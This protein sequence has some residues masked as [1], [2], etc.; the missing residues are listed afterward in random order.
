MEETVEALAA[1]AGGKA[2]G[3]TQRR[4]R[5]AAALEGASE[6]HI[7]FADSPR[8]LEQALATAAGCIVVAEGAESRGRTVIRA[9]NPKL[10]FARI[11][12]RLHPSPRP[13]P[14]IHR[15]AI[16]E[17]TARVGEGASI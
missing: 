11:A 9:R 10:A 15:S 12:A 7:V 4:V 16:V 6:H 1:L 2:E 5:A 3:E 14:G 8:A 13:E 17:G